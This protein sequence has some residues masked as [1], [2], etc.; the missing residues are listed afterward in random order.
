MTTRSELTEPHQDEDALDRRKKKVGQSIGDEGNPEGQRNDQPNEKIE[1]EIPSKPLT[2]FFHLSMSDET[3]FDD[4]VTRQLPQE[5][6][7][8]HHD[9]C[10]RIK[11]QLIRGKMQLFT[12]E[13]T[14]WTH[15]RRHCCFEIDIQRNPIVNLYPQSS[16]G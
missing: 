9:R 8:G 10:L 3:R 2:A 16:V 11:H 1:E 14:E 7:L 12:E 6:L 15:R 4:R 13:T 5:I